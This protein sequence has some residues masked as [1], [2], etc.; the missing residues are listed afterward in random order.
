MLISE[1]SRSIKH[2][3]CEIYDPLNR[4]HY[5]SQE[6]G[7]YGDTLT[8]KGDLCGEAFCELWELVVWRQGPGTLG[9][10]ESDYA[11]T[12]VSS[13]PKQTR[14]FMNRAPAASRPRP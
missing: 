10:T 11:D 3:M 14:R 8:A 7:A 6:T 4:S 5:F 12:M 2:W 9:D 1:Q 13:G